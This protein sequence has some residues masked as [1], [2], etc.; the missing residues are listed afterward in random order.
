MKTGNLEVYGV[1]YKIKN[2]INNKVYIGQ[3][4]NG[5]DVR[6]KGNLEKYTHNE[7]LKKSLH[8]YG[9]ENFD[10]SKIFDV[11]FNKNEL[12]IKEK[13]WIKIYKS[14]DEKYGYNLD[15]GGANGKP[16]EHTR[17]L[18][19]ISHSKENHPMWGKKVSLETIAKIKNTCSKKLKGNNHP[20]FGKHLSNNQKKNISV[21]LKEYYDNHVS[22][23]K[24]KHYDSYS[25]KRHPNATSV[26]CLNTGEIFDYIGQAKIKYK[27]NDIGR[28]CKGYLKSTGKHPLTGE[29]LRWMYYKDYINKINIAS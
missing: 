19:S 15:D 6:Y 13:S 24:G 2:K 8:K 25:G 21:S 10:I 18:L 9:I 22:P 28:A 27:T 14:T 1:I 23:N 12:D 20:M 17:K 3:T 26:I 4:I 29:K 16:N 5:F 7:H 11:A